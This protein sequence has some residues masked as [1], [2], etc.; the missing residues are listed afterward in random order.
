LRLV[1]VGNNA[2]FRLDAKLDGRRRSHEPWAADKTSKREYVA[3][4]EGKESRSLLQPL[5][6]IA[7]NNILGQNCSTLP[8]N[9]TDKMI[10][11]PP[12]E[13]MIVTRR[14]VVVSL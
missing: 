12:R 11:G 8:P 2:D 13:L 5:C 14:L 6:V 10:P 1:T 7:R 9:A 3:S 4:T